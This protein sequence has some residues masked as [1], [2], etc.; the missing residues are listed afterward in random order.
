MNSK[1]GKIFFVLPIV[2]IAILSLN[3]CSTDP[4]QS[5]QTVNGQV[6]YDFGYLQNAKVEIDGKLTTT[7][8]EGK[9]SIPDINM[10]YDLKV[11]TSNGLDLM[12]INDLSNPNPFVNF[13]FGYFQ[14]TTKMSAQ[15]EATLDSMPKSNQRVFSVFVPDDG[16]PEVLSYYT[17]SSPG[18]VIRTDAYWFGPPSVSGKLVIYIYTKAGE[19]ILSFDKAYVKNNVVLSNNT[20][21]NIPFNFPTAFIANTSVSG[22]VDNQGMSVDLRMKLKFKNSITQNPLS[23]LIFSQNFYFIVPDSNAAGLFDVEI[24]A[25]Y[26]NSKYS[27]RIVKPGTH[28]IN[29]KLNDPVTLTSP[30]NNSIGYLN[31]MIYSWQPSVPAGKLYMLEMNCTT[32]FRRIRVYTTNLQTQLPDLS[33]VG[34]SLD[35]AKTFSWEVFE[36]YGFNNMDSFFNGNFSQSPAFQGYSISESRM[37]HLL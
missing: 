14:T 25:Y 12:I 4:V 9:F 13:E 35:Q 26:S 23:Q 28:N 24:E 21:G 33:T 37:I 11:M 16:Q 22:T 30:D 17:G 10:P 2:I 5:I 6:G 1:R 15:I 19:K 34:F 8:D 36:Y 32:P 3:S 31:S 20:I 29:I 27:Q 18:N 7:D